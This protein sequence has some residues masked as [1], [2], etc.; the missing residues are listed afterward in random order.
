[1][2]RDSTNKSRKFAE[3]F[4]GNAVNAAGLEPERKRKTA[5]LPPRAEQHFTVF[6]TL[7]RAV[8]RA[9]LLAE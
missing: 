7:L 4:S 6:A 3:K 2:N 5:A 9:C 1:M 8:G